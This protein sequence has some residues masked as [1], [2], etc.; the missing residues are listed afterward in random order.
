ML[1]PSRSTARALDAEQRI[2]DGLEVAEVLGEEVGVGLRRA[3][4]QP[5]PRQS[6]RDHVALLGERVDDELERRRH[7]HPAVQHDQRRP[8]GAIESWFAPDENV[9]A[10]APRVD[11]AA[12][13]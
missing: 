1:W 6:R 2:E 12:A 5:K 8:S 3:R 11:E 10:Q 13:R 4:W 7:V 9:L